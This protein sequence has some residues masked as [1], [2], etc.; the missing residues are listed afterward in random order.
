MSHSLLTS[1]AAQLHHQ[2]GIGGSGNTSSSERNNWQSLQSG[3]LLE[4]VVRCGELL[5]KGVKLLIGHGGGSSNVGHDGP[6]VSDGLDD[7][8]GPSLTL[9]SNHTASEW[10]A[11]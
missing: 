7:V 5:G 11:G 1:V 4:E 2:G 3:S 6:L 9:G 10:M 8:P